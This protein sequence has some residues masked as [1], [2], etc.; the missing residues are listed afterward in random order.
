[1]RVLGFYGKRESEDTA[2]WKNKAWTIAVMPRDETVFGFNSCKCSP[3]SS[4]PSHG[5]AIRLPLRRKIPSWPC[6][7]PT[8]LL[9]KLDLLL[10]A[11]G[12][13]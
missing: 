3:H 11:L 4:S 6:L 5:T 8:A 13:C 7:P 2:T 9:F 12:W 10:T 1:M